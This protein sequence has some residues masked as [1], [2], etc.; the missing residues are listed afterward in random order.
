M[1][2]RMTTTH[3]EESLRTR[4]SSLSNTNEEEIDQGRGFSTTR[5]EESTLISSEESMRTATQNGVLGLLLPNREKEDW[6][7][8]PKH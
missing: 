8:I 6:G 1:N 7:S 5:K 3:I 2:E 4:R